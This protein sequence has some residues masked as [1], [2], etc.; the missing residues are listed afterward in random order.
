M[1]KAEKLKEILPD[2]PDAHGNLKKEGATSL[3]GPCPKCGGVDR[4]VFKTDSN[5]F[6]CRYCYPEDKPG[7]KIDY[8]LWIDGLDFKGLL[9]KYLPEQG[10]KKK[11]S[12]KTKPFEHYQLGYP[13]E[14]YPYTDEKG[15]VLYYSC[16]FDPKAFRQCS[17]DGLSWTVKDIK[18]FPYQLLKILKA[19]LVFIHG[20]EKACNRMNDIGQVGACNVAGEG[21]WTSCLNPY[22]KGK[23]IILIPDNDDKGR[24]HVEKVYHELRDI[25]ASIKLIELP[26]LPEKGDFADWLDGFDDMETAAERLLVMVDNAGPYEPSKNETE[27][28]D[29]PKIE[30][31]SLDSIAAAEIQDRPIVKG[32]LGEKESLI[33][34]GPSGGGKSG[35]VTITALSAGNPPENGLWGLFPIPN[36]VKTLIVQSE[37]GLNPFNRRL[38][39]LFNAHPEM[40]AGAKNVFTTKIGDDC[41]MVGSL[42]DKDFQKF[43]IDSLISIEAGLLILDPLISYHGEDENDNAAMR[44]SLDCLTLICDQANVAV[45]LCHHYNRQNLTRGAASIRDW[46]ANMLLMDIEKQSN[47]STFLKITHDK[48]RN[49]EQQPDFYLERTPDLQFLRCE[50]PD[51][52]QSNQMEAV[53]AALTEMGGQVD[54]QTHFKSAVMVGLNCSEATARRAIEQALKLRK[55]II[56]PGKGKG[57]SN[58]Y[59][60]PD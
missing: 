19:E 5:R 35:L 20:G 21:N 55:I 25:A 29:N 47:G 17:A 60:L 54:S 41:R 9:Q 11:P 49:Y 32:L 34:S 24:K 57:H 48:S 30:I 16:R 1:T 42:T 23:E 44:R 10:S 12:K 52:K 59:K 27:N 31:V 38:N 4:F 8:H 26:G 22:F 40:R 3:C 15:Q 51:G 7:G 39:K 50:K 58:S 18:K 56:I 37:N 43:L 14:K 36:I 53:I 13:V 28:K 45:I 2:I 46:A 6:W 33:I